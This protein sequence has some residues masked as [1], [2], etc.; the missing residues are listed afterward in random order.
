MTTE[1]AWNCELWLVNT[2][3]LVSNK[4]K[5]R[6]Q[7]VQNTA[8][9]VMTGNRKYDHITPVLR[10]LHWLPV[11]QRI[12]FKLAMA[13]FK[14]IHS[15]APSY[16]TGDCVLASSVAGRRHLRSA[17]ARTPVLR[18]TKTAIDTREFFSAAVAWNCLP[19]ELRRLS[20]SVQT[21]ALILKKHLFISCYK[22]IWGFSISRYT[23]YHYHHHYYY[24][25]YYRPAV[26]YCT[27]IQVVV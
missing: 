10:D 13:V 12:I 11:R 17:N 14:Y 20:C 27:D 2:F 1:T 19:L 18:R 15:L 5:G 21:F 3:T 4:D 22:R 8:A 26:G 9:R 25:Y 24:Y 23:N 16:L 6:L 7:L